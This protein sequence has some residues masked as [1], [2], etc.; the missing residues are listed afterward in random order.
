VCILFY[1]FRDLIITLHVDDEASIVKRFLHGTGHFTPNFS[2]T[3]KELEAAMNAVMH[4]RN[5][6]CPQLERTLHLA[7]SLIEVRSSSCTYISSELEL[8]VP[9]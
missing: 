1:L 4:E 5:I 9:T 2:S 7:A 8:T 3:N 6:Q